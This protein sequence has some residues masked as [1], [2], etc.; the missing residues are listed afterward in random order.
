MTSR[1]ENYLTVDE[2]CEVCNAFQKRLMVTDSLMVANIILIRKG[3]K[4]AKRD[5][6]EVFLQETAPHLWGAFKLK[7]PQSSIIARVDNRVKD[8]V[9]A[10]RGQNP[11]AKSGPHPPHA[12]FSDEWSD[13]KESEQP[14][15][16]KSFDSAVYRELILEKEKLKK[17]RDAEPKTYN[18]EKE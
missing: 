1:L 6:M 16:N 3:I 11:D 14:Y 10:F 4:P 8:I 9:N 18:K 17:Q 13:M 7:R 5:A 2:R 15:R 12:P